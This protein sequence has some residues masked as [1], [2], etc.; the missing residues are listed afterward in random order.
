MTRISRFAALVAA[1]VTALTLT[2]CST[3]VNGTPSPDPQVT[4]AP[5]GTSPEDALKSLEACPVLDQLLSGQGF[6]PGERITRRNECDA[7][8]PGYGTVGIALDPLQG[9]TDT[10]HQDPAATAL[11]INGRKALVGEFTGP[12]TCEVALEVAEH[13][14]ASAAA[15]LLGTDRQAEACSA[16]RD[17]ATKLEPL[18]PK[19]R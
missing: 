10:Q 18:L 3:M 4:A 14:R 13:A 8:K 1:A 12:G 9:L 19:P 7:T 17:L 5:S 15:V 16:A 2:G 6:A 11:E